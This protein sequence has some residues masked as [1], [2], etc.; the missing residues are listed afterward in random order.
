[1]FEM[2]MSEFLAIF[3][4]PTC[5]VK[6]VRMADSMEYVALLALHAQHQF[7]RHT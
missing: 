3:D 2:T 4:R 1:M 6:A 5:A 7:G